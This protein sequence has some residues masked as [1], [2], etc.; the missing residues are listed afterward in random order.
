MMTSTLLTPWLAPG[1]EGATAGPGN[2]PPEAE[3]LGLGCADGECDDPHAAT[4]A[5]AIRS[6]PARRIPVRGDRW[7][8]PPSVDRI[9]DGQWAPP[10]ADP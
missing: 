3:L 1:P 6:E 7:V 9:K 10:P 8:P 4:S 2:P 5:E